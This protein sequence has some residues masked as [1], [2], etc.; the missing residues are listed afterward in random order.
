MRLLY[1]FAIHIIYVLINVCI[2]YFEFSSLQ[3][4]VKEVAK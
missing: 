3:Y 1:E 2:V 4:R